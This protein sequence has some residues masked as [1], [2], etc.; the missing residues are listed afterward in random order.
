MQFIGRLRTPKRIKKPLLIQTYPKQP[1]TRICLVGRSAHP[2]NPL[3]RMIPYNANCGSDS[4]TS[5]V[6]SRK[7]ADRSR[8]VRHQLFFVLGRGVVEDQQPVAMLLVEAS[9]FRCLAE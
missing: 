7:F 4:T 5:K 1:Q 2:D 9:H 8:P 3:Q 6:A